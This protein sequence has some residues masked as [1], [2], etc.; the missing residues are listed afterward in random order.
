M[1]NHDTYKSIEIFC[2]KTLFQYQFGR[3]LIPNKEIDNIGFR[4][5]WKNS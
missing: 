3:L 1:Y 4:T 2:F 5:T